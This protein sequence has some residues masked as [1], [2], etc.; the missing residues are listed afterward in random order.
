MEKIC[1]HTQ[2]TFWVILA[3]VNIVTGITLGSIRM[4][5]T[6]EDVVQPNYITLSTQ[7]NKAHALI[8]QRIDQTNQRVDGIQITVDHLKRDF[9]MN[10]QDSTIARNP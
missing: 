8:N 9:E 2:Y 6:G 7:A 1:K 3:A 4:Y 10:K 5:V